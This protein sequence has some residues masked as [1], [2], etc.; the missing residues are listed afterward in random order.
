MNIYSIIKLISLIVH[1]ILGGYAIGKS[2]RNR[3]NQSFSLAV[4]S[5]A[6]M[7]FG[8]FMLMISSNFVF[9]I[10]IAFFGQC[11]VAVNIILFSLIYGRKNYRDSLKSGKVYLIILYSVFVVLAIGVLSGVVNFRFSNESANYRFIFGKKGS[12]LIIF[13][14]ICDL[15]ALVNLENTYHQIKERRRIQYPTIVFI[16]MLSFSLFIYSLT[17]G[18]SYMQVNVIAIE[19]VIMIIS[20][21][22]IA[23][24]VL[25]PEPKLNDIYVGRVVIA[26]SYTLLL[27]G[28]YLLVAGLLGK[29]IQEIGENISFF[30][31][32]LIAFLVILIL[33]VVLVSKSL[34]QR[35]QLFVERNFYR[36]KYDYRKEWEN[37]SKNVFSI[38][39]MN[40]LLQ[41]ILN[42]VSE[43]IGA[44]RAFIM[45]LDNNKKEFFIAIPEVDEH[46]VKDIT[47]PVNDVFLD[48]LW[49]YGS[50][51]RIENGKCMINKVFNNPPNVPDSIL[52]IF[53][54]ETHNEKH[55]TENIFFV[56][57]IA[58]NKLITIIILRCLKKIQKD[59]ELGKK[60][61]IM[62]ARYIQEDI[63]LL[64]TMANQISIAIINAKK[65]QE[66]VLSRELESF[67]RLSSMLLHDLKNS[68]Y[69]L[70]L[71]MQNTA[72]NFD[73]PEFQKDAINTISNVVEKIQK[74]ISKL[75][76]APQ[77]EIFQ[78]LQPVDFVEIVNNAIATSGIRNM[79]KIKVIEELNP[80]PKLMSDP[81]NMERVIL[82]LIVNATESIINEG[83]ITMK[84]SQISNEFIQISIS[85][86]GCGISQEF[87]RNQLFKPFQTT[88]SKGLGIGLY[89]CK[90]IID[91]CDGIIEV[92]SQQGVG[93]TFII[94]LPI[95]NKIDEADI[96][97]SLGS[98]II[99]NS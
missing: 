12:V 73:N 40:E 65:S 78:N 88:K 3:L 53:A 57:I 71:V 52:N 86:T 18:F 90:S 28:I 5:I 67:Y 6:I 49:R 99:N 41:E 43:T 54:Q 22:F 68:A 4:F 79:V 97:A 74:I 42:T 91:A 80:V 89:Q 56:P 50:P 9:W 70:S 47:I 20:N 26:R 46:K 69:M 32:F 36:N 63:E 13:L 16:A 14:L 62:E 82:N 84:T 34:K 95:V 8:Y 33:M 93:S 10:R 87:I 23:Y 51:I 24:P 15:I 61:K 94:K 66:L 55:F 7:E 48:W 96:Q 38:L 1:A 2:P 29:I 31:S 98:C 27:A 60:Y 39:N 85:D 25:R 75:S 37:F 44:D 35:F 83:V 72:D 64:E 30:L 21:L 11:L 81:E 77:K 45:L 59:R 92:Q 76:S 19:S 58:E 17:L